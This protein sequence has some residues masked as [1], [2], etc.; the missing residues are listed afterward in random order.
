MADIV[1]NYKIQQKL[2]DGMLTL[3]PETYAGI[4]STD[5]FAVTIGDEEK[6]YEA[7]NVQKILELLAEEIEIASAGGVTGIKIKTDETDPK[8]QTGVVTVDLTKL[9]GIS[10][11][12]NKVEASESNGK[13][14]IDGVETVVYDESKAPVYSIAKDADSSDYAG[15]YHMTKTVDGVTT[16]VGD[17]INIPK[18]LVVKSGSIVERDGDKYLQLVLN[19]EAATKIDVKVTELVDD[20]TAGTGVKI[21]SRVVS[22]DRTTTDT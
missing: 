1:K 15:V 7:S 16:N 13:I 19:D 8:A 21:D 5:A 14:K 4:V 22:I 2:K 9:T 11:G 20:Y 3:H 6:N 10:E 17:A 18:D 12:A